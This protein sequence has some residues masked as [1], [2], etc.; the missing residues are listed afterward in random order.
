RPGPVEALSP[1]RRA[2]GEHLSR[3]ADEHAADL[4]S[5]RVGGDDTAAAALLQEIGFFFVETALCVTRLPRLSGP[6]PE[7][8]VTT[9]PPPP[10]DR[11][12][13]LA[14]A[15]KAFH[16]GRYHA[17][18]RFPQALADRRYRCWLENALDRPTPGTRVHVIGPA[19]RPVGFL[20]AEVKGD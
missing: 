4:V 12:P 1:D 15:E 6:L 18:G 3:W 16:H 5:C 19:G 10:V 14:I 13:L 2:V 8:R 17:D 7:A 11:G 20:H 9:R